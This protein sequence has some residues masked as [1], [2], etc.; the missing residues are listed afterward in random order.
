M[1]S[2]NHIQRQLLTV[3]RN[4]LCHDHLHGVNANANVRVCIRCARVTL[5][6]AD[7]AIAMSASAAPVFLL[8][9]L[10]CHA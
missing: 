7:A 3:G 9:P 6:C 10:H 4:S 2:L 1:I 8:I 5:L